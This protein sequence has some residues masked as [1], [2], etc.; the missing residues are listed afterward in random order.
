MD[1]QVSLWFNQSI[2]HNCS[3]CGFLIRWHALLAWIMHSNHWILFNESKIWFRW[4]HFINFLISYLICLFVWLDTGLNYDEHNKFHKIDFTQ[5]RIAFAAITGETANLTKLRGLTQPQLIVLINFLYNNCHTEI[6]K[7]KTST[8]VYIYCYEFIQKNCF[9]ELSKDE[10]G[11]ILD[12]L[13]DIRL[14]IGGK[15]LHGKL[16]IKNNPYL[17]SNVNQ[18]KSFVCLFVCFVINFLIFCLTNCVCLVVSGHINWMCRLK[19]CCYW[20][21]P[22]CLTFIE[23]CW[24][25]RKQWKKK[26]WNP[27]ITHNSMDERTFEWRFVKNIEMLWNI[28]KAKENE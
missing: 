8:D 12:S 1:N 14:I 4:V 27:E 25:K 9:N 5:C 2:I 13:V 18:T 17:V 23:T 7:Y 28:E 3:N 16:A 26:N 19:K 10:I 21:Q 6:N 11:R 15:P 20:S 22:N 24:P